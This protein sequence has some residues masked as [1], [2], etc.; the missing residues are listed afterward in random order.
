MV[1]QGKKTIRRGI[2]QETP[3]QGS[4][5]IHSMEGTKMGALADVAMLLQFTLG[6]MVC[7]GATLTP[8]ITAYPCFDLVGGKLGKRG[9]LT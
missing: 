1:C 7:P 5:G 2:R 9:T 6:S 8:V 3:F 4:T